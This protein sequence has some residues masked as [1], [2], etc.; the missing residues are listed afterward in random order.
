MSK[1]NHAAFKVPKLIEFRDELPKTAVGKILEDRQV[2]G[3]FIWRGSLDE[4][5]L[6][7]STLQSGE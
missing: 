5:I 4:R 6:N 2:G 3:V 7:R 1:K